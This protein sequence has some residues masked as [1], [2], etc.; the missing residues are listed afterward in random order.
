[1]RK[2]IKSLLIVS[3]VISNTLSYSFA[4]RGVRSRSKKNISLN[5]NTSNNFRSSLNLNLK[6][7]LKYNGIEFSE[8][9]PPSCFIQ[10]SS[11]KLFQKG[12]TIYLMP[13]QQK[14]IIPEIKQG[15]TGMKLILKP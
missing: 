15:Y 1:M 5:I 3:V 6:T 13:S 11:V 2:F 7:G 14:I 12:N 9:T 4:D 8:N 10:G